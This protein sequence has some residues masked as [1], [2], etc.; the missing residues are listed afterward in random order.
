[1][2]TPEKGGGAIS[3]GNFK[4]TKP[5][6]VNM[7]DS[8][9]EKRERAVSHTNLHKQSLQPALRTLHLR[10]GEGQAPVRTLNK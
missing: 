3:H 10:R 1:L 9:P 8:A 7:Q 2:S 5:V 6:R 4:Y